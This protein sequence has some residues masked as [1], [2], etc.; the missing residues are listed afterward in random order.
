MP[1]HNF[2][3]QMFNV[4]NYDVP[5]NLMHH[6]GIIFYI[7]IHVFARVSKNYILRL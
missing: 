6:E 4:G 5:V 1:V 3:F 2:Y 7:E